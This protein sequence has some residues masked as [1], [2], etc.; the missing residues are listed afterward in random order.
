M[1]SGGCY[2]E[3]LIVDAQVTLEESFVRIL[4]C[5]LEN[6]KNRAHWFQIFQRSYC[7]SIRRRYYWNRRT[8]W[9]R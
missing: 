7:G 8:K 1:D 5:Y 2:I 3:P 6:Q 9:L 4:G